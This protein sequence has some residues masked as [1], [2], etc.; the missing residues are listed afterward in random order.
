MM[1]AVSALFTLHLDSKAAG[2]LARRANT[3]QRT[4]KQF[5]LDTPLVFVVNF[6]LTQVLASAKWLSTI[7]LIEIFTG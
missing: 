1:M 4:G 7:Q 2:D 6:L 5:Y 3:P